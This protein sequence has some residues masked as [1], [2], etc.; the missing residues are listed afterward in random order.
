[1]VC[2]AAVSGNGEKLGFPA[3]KPPLQIS[4]STSTEAAEI[5]PRFHSDFQATKMPALKGTVTR[6]STDT[7]T[8]PEPFP[9]S[10]GIPLLSREILSQLHFI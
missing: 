9:I 5:L 3:K 4:F 10:T 6:C 2:S 7:D 1:M 8:E